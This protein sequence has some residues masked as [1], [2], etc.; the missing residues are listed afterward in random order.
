VLTDY[1][2]YVGHNTRKALELCAEAT[3]AHEYKNWWWKARLGKCYYKL[4]EGPG[5]VHTYLSTI[6]RLR[7][8]M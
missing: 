7:T 4:G 6:F 3:K 5:H 8:E 2:L 1:L